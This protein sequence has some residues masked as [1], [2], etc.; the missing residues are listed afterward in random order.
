MLALNHKRPSSLAAFPLPLHLFFPPRTAP[1]PYWL[2]ASAVSH[3]L[4]PWHSCKCCITRLPQFPP[5]WTEDSV[6]TYP[7]ALPMMLFMLASP[8]G[9][10]RISPSCPFPASRSSAMVLPVL[11]SASQR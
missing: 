2:R 11:L 8:F 1:H 9:I 5:P 4:S 6:V 10:G 7:T 3:F